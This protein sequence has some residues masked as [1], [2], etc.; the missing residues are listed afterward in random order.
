MTSQQLNHNA[1]RVVREVA[2]ETFIEQATLDLVKLAR[3]THPQTVLGGPGRYKLFATTAT[4]D[5]DAGENPVDVSLLDVASL[6]RM[7]R[8]LLST[9]VTVV[10]E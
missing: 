5:V 4:P 3:R 2:V 7:A 10:F 9:R 6:W 1:A 8:G